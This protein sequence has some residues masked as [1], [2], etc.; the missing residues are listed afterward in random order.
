LTA[1][2]SLA[3]MRLF[4]LVQLVYRTQNF[5]AFFAP[6]LLRSLLLLFHSYLLSPP[7]FMETRPTG[8]CAVSRARQPV[9][10][11]VPDA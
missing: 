11:A 9:K 1:L 8:I 5:A 10:Y 2:L 3:F 7:A 4:M 6:D